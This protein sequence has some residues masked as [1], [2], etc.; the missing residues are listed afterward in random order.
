MGQFDCRCVAE[1]RPFTGAALGKIATGL[2]NRKGVHVAG[3]EDVKVGGAHHS[4]QSP[5]KVPIDAALLTTGNRGETTGLHNS[6]LYQSAQA[7]AGQQR[8]RRGR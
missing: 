2:I 1:A 4:P 6:S 8:D 3:P 5:M 7:P